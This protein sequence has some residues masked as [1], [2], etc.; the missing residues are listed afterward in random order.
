[1]T[2][3]E[4]KALPFDEVF[5]TGILPNS[6]DGIFMTND[7]GK[8]R[9]VAKKGRINDWAV[10]CHWDYKSEEYVKTNG[11]KLFE[12]THIQRCVPCTEEVMKLYR[13]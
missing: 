1:M 7:G 12:E 8:L 13:H 11:D 9:W 3:D 5:A 2:L 10:Y 4:F 6:P